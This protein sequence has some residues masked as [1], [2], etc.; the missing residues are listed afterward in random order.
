M[1]FGWSV[2][3]LVAAIEILFKVGKALRDSD[4][5]A[6]TYQEDSLFLESLAATLEKIKQSIEDGSLPKALGIQIKAVRD[7]IMEMQQKLSTKFQA[8]LGKDDSK[9]F[10][11]F[12]SS[13]PKKLEYGLFVAEQ[14]K[15]LR[16]RIAIPLQDIQLNL[17]LHTLIMVSGLSTSLSNL[18]VNVIDT[19]QS[20]IQT[21]LAAY[22]VEPKKD[23]DPSVRQH[24]LQWLKP[25][26][27]EETYKDSLLGML[28]GSCEWLFSRPE[29]LSWSQHAKTDESSS[30]LWVTGIPGAGKTT[31]AACTIQRLLNEH[32]V[33]Y[34]YCD[35]KRAATREGVAVLRT[36]LWQLLL[37]SDDGLEDVEKIYKTGTE[38][39]RVNMED[40]LSILLQNASAKRI[41]VLDGLDECDAHERANICQSLT[42]IS[43]H[44]NILIFSRELGDIAIG[45][46]KAL[47]SQQWK[48]LQITEA[49]TDPDIKRFIEAEVQLLGLPN[50]D[51]ER[52]VITKLQDGA[53]GMFQ[54]ADQMIK[55][56]AEPGKI[57]AEEYLEALQ[58]LPQSLD[59]L[60][61][62][63]LTA[64][65][66]NNAPRLRARSKLIF[67]WLVC[68]SRPLTLSEVAA[69]LK[70]TVGQ[71]RMPSWAAVDVST[72]KRAISHCCGTLVRVDDSNGSKS[73]VTLV[74]AS[75]KDFLSDP[76]HTN[77]PFRDLIVDHQAAHALIAQSCLTY[78]CY[79]DIP[80]APFA[81]E[82][83]D[84]GQTKETRD[85][86]SEKFVRH[87]D[88]FPLLEYAALNWI[89]HSLASLHSSQ[90]SLAANQRALRQFYTSIPNT[91]RW[92]QI[93][94]RLCGDRFIWLNSRALR[95]IDHIS[96]VKGCLVDGVDEY[97]EWLDHL[98]GPKHGRFIRWE[99][100]MN[101]GDANDLLP[102]LHIAA[103]F[104]FPD[105]LTEGLSRGI[106]VNQRTLERQTPL[107]LAARGD[108][109]RTANI[110][111]KSGAE[112]NASG[113]GENTA[114]SWGIDVD[115]YMN[116][117]QSGPFDVVPILLKAG[118]DPNLVYGHGLPLYRACQIPHPDDPFVL[119]L[120]RLLLKHGAAK[121]I[122][123]HPEEQSPL[124]CAAILGA[125]ELA[126]I[127][128][129]NG[130]NV[131]GPPP[132]RP[133]K[134]RQYPLLT[135]VAK[136]KPS[137]EATR[138][139]LEAGANVNAEAQDG[140]TPLHFSIR[141][142]LEITILLLKYGA[143]VNKRAADGSLPLHDA[144]QEN[145]I[146][147]IKTLIDCG[148]DLDTE[149]ET[150]RPP[151]VIAIQSQYHKAAADLIT[152][153]A[154]FESKSWQIL[155]T[156]SSMQMV[157]KKLVYWPQSPK[158]IFEVFSLIQFRLAKSPLRR[159][160]VLDI[161]EYAGYWLRSTSSEARKI[162]VDQNGAEL[163][164][165]YLLSNPIQGRKNAPVRQVKFVIRSHDQGWSSY[166]NQHGTYEGSYTWFDVAIWKSN[167]E[168][169]DFKDEASTLT[170]NVHASPKPREYC[171][172]YGRHSQRRH[173]RWI[174]WLEPGD[175][176]A[177]IPKALYPGWVNYVES[178]SIEVMSTCLRD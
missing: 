60:Y 77:D 122:D 174:D 116:H 37:Q 8:T 14:V 36:W 20:V 80:F 7:P 65:S 96:S 82:F 25:I 166:P 148:S 170:R 28:D 125:P 15:E 42:S 92:L 81:V 97:E 136:Q 171:I 140:R 48:R 27:V 69:V 71:P 47:G 109:V 167:G 22:F 114:L 104:D 78:L 153:G 145:N 120:V 38:P 41:L 127:L 19:V 58:D 156:G 9:S 113:W 175:R 150:G 2:G 108:S 85:T 138:V 44:A 32:I 55:N 147:A 144:V 91:I 74:H 11:R 173:C 84:F 86:M 79:E 67:Q 146:P 13:G 72:I 164:L 66:D 4:G 64:L 151:L 16:S 90:R 46:G 63:I 10:K 61:G 155:Q 31:L 112:V 128:L 88:L 54:W 172:L 139:L 177:I 159:S 163:G 115:G 100:F 43:G 162:K 49:D 83:D 158:D 123:G 3:D 17:G 107:I 176:V 135:L 56:L 111:L 102:E 18:S 94:L 152:G 119:A 110:L 133:Y 137:V 178:A 141:S 105:F 118:A 21:T 87:L 103:F 29:Y 154:S 126:R 132:D 157:R 6:A 57:F 70:I 169:V 129:E 106:D 39:N 45:L 121:Y 52:A 165:P 131:D 160:I 59:E 130:A 98:R 62:R 35:T 76:N 95:D 50:D 168:W 30:L 75:V 53:Q 68:A 142:T 33:A 34:F 99:R 134:L 26:S 12:L 143:N 73:M 23:K 149:D 1:S 124:G 40:C 51:I 101:S 117:K 93:Y 89:F 24:V 5:A 161:M